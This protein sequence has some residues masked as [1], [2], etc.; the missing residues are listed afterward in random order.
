VKPLAQIASLLCV[1]LLTATSAG[2]SQPLKMHASSHSP[3]CLTVLLRVEPDADNRVLF[4]AARTG[5]FYRSSETDLD[6]AQAPRTMVFQLRVPA[7]EYEVTGILVGPKGPRAKVRTMVR[8]L[9]VPNKSNVRCDA[10][11]S[12]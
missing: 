2:T 4:V 7:D 10:P 11:A 8:V 12:R 9:A 5:D 6:G 3:A 1:C